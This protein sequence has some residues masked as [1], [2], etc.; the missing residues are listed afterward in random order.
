[1]PGPLSQLRKQYVGPDGS[2]VSQQ[3]DAASVE[4]ALA[5]VKLKYDPAEYHAKLRNA[6]ESFL[7]EGPGKATFEGR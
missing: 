6:V 7:S 4:R 1:M 5:G 3:M 2:V